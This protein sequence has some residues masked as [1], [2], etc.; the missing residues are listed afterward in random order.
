MLDIFISKEY[1]VENCVLRHCHYEK[2][3]AR[4]VPLHS[5]SFHPPHVHRSWPVTE[6]K[7]RHDHSCSQA[8]FLQHKLRY[9]NKLRHFAFPSRI[10]Q[11]CEGWA[12]HSNG[13]LQRRASKSD[14]IIVRV[15]V[16]F[17]RQVFGLQRLLN[18]VVDRWNPL[19]VQLCG[20]SVAVQV[21]FRNA[22]RP[23]SIV[24][25]HLRF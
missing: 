9:V 14:S 3:S 11:S 18:A 19:L 10:V 6:V 12:P 21:A 4:H 7:R 2:P 13:T 22:S 24:L 15:V 1:R 16:G 25:R 8:A 17:H 20:K 5:S 23:L